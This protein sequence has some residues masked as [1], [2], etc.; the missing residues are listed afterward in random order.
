MVKEKKIKNFQ[1]KSLTLAYEIFFPDGNENMITATFVTLFSGETKTDNKLALISLS[2]KLKFNLKKHA[3]KNNKQTK[4]KISFE[5]CTVYGQ[6]SFSVTCYNVLKFGI[7]CIKRK[8][9]SW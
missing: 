2:N 6:T 1:L 4:A 3:Y 5:F 8:E 7:L 9:N